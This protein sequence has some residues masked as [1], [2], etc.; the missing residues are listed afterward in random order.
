MVEAG[1]SLEDAA[2]AFSLLDSYVYGFG[3]QQSNFTGEGDASSEEMAA[4]ILE[5]IPPEEYPHL[6]RMA[7]HAMEAGYDAESDFEF[8]LEII[9]DGLQRALATAEQSGS[10]ELGG[11]DDSEEC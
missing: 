1:F 5:S 11:H 7:V 2:R 6:H 3:I 9:L 4:A 10:D 8:G